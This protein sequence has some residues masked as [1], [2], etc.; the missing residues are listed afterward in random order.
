MQSY[1][2]TVSAQLPQPNPDS[3]TGIAIVERLR[4]RGICPSL[5]DDGRIVLTP[6][7]SVTDRIRSYVADHARVVAD[8]LLTDITRLAALRCAELWSG[9]SAQLLDD[10]RLQEIQRRTNDAARRM[11]VAAVRRGCDELVAWVRALANRE[12]AR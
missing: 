4:A 1:Q 12:A 8:A 9:S 3:V 7:S 10:P 11:D 5:G 6:A 2:H